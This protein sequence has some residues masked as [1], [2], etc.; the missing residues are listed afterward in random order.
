MKFFVSVRYDGSQDTCSRTETLLLQL[1]YSLFCSLNR[2]LTSP[3]S[4]PKVSFLEFVWVIT[5][6]LKILL[7][8]KKIKIVCANIACNLAQDGCGI[9]SS[10][11]ICA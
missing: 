1:A 7:T 2:R 3:V 6:I 11:T 10:S 5:E 9:S 8:K 4:L